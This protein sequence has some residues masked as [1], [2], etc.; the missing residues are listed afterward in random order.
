M[1]KAADPE[2][3]AA[4]NHPAAVRAVPAAETKA[5]VE[6]ATVI[7]AGTAVVTP[8]PAAVKPAAARTRAAVA[9]AAV[10][11]AVKAA[12]VPEPA[13]KAVPRPE[14]KAA[15]AVEPGQVAGTPLMEVPAVQPEVIPVP[16]LPHR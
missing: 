9:K 7:K 16:A 11:A 5:A 10:K 14:V 2:T 15:P 6:P 3:A 13:A 8:V 12:P 1:Q 4:R